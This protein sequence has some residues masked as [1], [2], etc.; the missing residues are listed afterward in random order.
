MHYA[1]YDHYHNG[2][3]K[4][5]QHVKSLCRD[6]REIPTFEKDGITYCTDISKANVLNEH[7][8]SVFTKDDDSI[9]PEMAGT[10][11]QI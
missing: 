6:P 7:F 8:Y 2:R 9:L 4:F 5:F 11:Y 3:K 1:I 10:Q